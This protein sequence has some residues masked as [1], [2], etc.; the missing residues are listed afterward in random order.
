MSLFC[1]VS[2]WLKLSGQAPAELESFQHGG[3]SDRHRLGTALAG[4]WRV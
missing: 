1:G 4:I 2:P 3:N